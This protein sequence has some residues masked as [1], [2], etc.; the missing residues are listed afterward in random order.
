M[1][2][3]IEVD[4]RDPVSDYYLEHIVVDMLTNGLTTFEDK[5]AYDVTVKAAKDKKTIKDT[6]TVTIK[7][8]IQDL[9][10]NLREVTKGMKVED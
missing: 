5:R 9:G 2:D 3:K 1:G 4:R 10:E 7:V 6:V 8:E